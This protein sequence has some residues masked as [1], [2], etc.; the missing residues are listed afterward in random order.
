MDFVASTHEFACHNPELKHAER[1]N[2]RAKHG[3]RPTSSR[4]R[5]AI[6]SMLGPDGA[7]GIAAL[8]LYA[9][10]GGVGFD[11]LD[12]GALHV[13]FVEIDRRRAAKID[14][15]IATRNLNEKAS[16][17]PTDAIRVL[18]HLAGKS[19]DLVF[20]DPP[21][22]LDPWQKVIAE[23]HNHKLLKPDAWIIAEHGSRH[24]LPDQISGAK[25]INRKRYGDTSITIYKFPSS[26]ETDI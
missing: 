18:R 2:R 14:Q 11:L 23:L 12:H 19:Y 4:T 21:Y 20:A 3:L 8:D 25:A 9:G 26:N 22:D 6:I 5:A 15:E 10:T 1:K 17:Y 24:T 13:D 16:T 7:N